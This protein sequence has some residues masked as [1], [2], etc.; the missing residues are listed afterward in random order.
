MQI[1]KMHTNDGWQVN[2]TKDIYIYFDEV[3]DWGSNIML[4]RYGQPTGGMWPPESD[5]FLI[6]WEKLQNELS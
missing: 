4:K 3:K 1:N 6:Q 5:R 2:I